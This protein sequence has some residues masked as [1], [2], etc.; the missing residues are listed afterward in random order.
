TGFVQNGRLEVYM[1]VT[2]IVLAAALLV[3]MIG[4][5]EL[6][7][8]PSFAGMRIYEAGVLAVA[9]VGLGAVLYARSRLAAIASLGIQG[10]AVAVLF[11]LFGAADLSFT[12]FMVETL[13]V[14]ILALVMTRLKL[15]PADRRPSRRR[16]FD[17]SVASLCGLGLALILLRVVQMP[18]DPALSTFFAEYERVIAHGRNI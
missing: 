7:Q 5:A 8:M 13:T 12:Q 6:P 14:V 4:F 2:F 16:V 1:S 3:P 9:L 11:M 18:F 10:F 17:V 15:S